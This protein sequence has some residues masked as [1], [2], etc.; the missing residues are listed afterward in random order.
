MDLLI[1]DVFRNAARAV[2]DRMAAAL[3]ADSLTFRQI[4]QESNKV[5]RALGGLGI[6]TG[7]RVAVWSGTNLNVDLVFAALAKLGAAFAPLNALFGPAEIE[8]TARLARPA[9]LL[10]DGD[11]AATGA[12]LATQLE[13][14]FADI[15]GTTAGGVAAGGD[16]AHLFA[17]AATESGEDPHATPALRAG[18]PHRTSCFSRAGAPGT[19]SEWSSPIGSTSCAAT[20]GHSWSPAAPW[21][22]PI[23][24][25]TWGRGRSPCSSG[26]PGTGW[27]SWLRP[28]A[29]PSAMPWRGTGPRGSTGGRRCGAGSSTTP[30]R[31]ASTISPPSASP[32]PGRRPP[33]WTS[34]SR[35][36]ASS[37]RPRC[38]CSTGRPRRGT[39][40]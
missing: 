32:T 24:S 3:G 25:S 7:D 22:A 17:R 10:A 16:G 37:P 15:E 9:L 19:P 40:R 8:G 12:Q 29:P 38:G 39:W 1:G 13:I 21:C 18:G 6:T 34:W 36:R 27:S 28:T 35:S 31:A 11:H 4:D 23:R 5:A 30:P 14:P 20:P 33:P 2:P 26:K